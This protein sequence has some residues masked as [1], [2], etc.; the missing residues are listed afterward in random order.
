MKRIN[1]STIGLLLIILTVAAYVPGGILDPATNAGVSMEYSHYKLHESDHYY[2]KGY[3][4]L[5]IGDSIIFAVT[6]ADSTKWPHL[7]YKYQS[8]G[9]IR[10]YTY[11]GG[12]YTGGASVTP[13]NNNRNSSNSSL[14]TIV[15]DPTSY[16]FGSALDSAKVGADGGFFGADVG[17]QSDREDESILKQ[18]EVYFFVVT[19]EAADNIIDFSSFWYEHIRLD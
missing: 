17:G 8:T 18:D 3:T 10:A 6:T 13:I 16:T 7:L 11:E 9:A 14:L 1:L 5:G 15:I 19:S 2:F 12:S 4:E